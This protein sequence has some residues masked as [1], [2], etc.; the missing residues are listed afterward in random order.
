MIW[1]QKICM[2]IPSRYNRKAHPIL[3]RTVNAHK[4][5]E[6]KKRYLLWSVSVGEPPV[7]PRTHRL[8][9]RGCLIGI[10]GQDEPNIK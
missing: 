1:G 10:Y 6:N 5:N 3:A 2:P 9:T 4:K 8:G 7:V